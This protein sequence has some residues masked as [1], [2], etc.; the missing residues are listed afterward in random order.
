[1]QCMYNT[2]SKLS[3]HSLHGPF[4][5]W[6][7]LW[8]DEFFVIYRLPDRR[9]TGMQ[10]TVRRPSGVSCPWPSLPRRITVVCGSCRLPPCTQVSSGCHFECNSVGY[11]ECRIEDSCLMLWFLMWFLMWFFDV[12]F[13]CSFSMF[14][15]ATSLTNCVLC[16]ILCWFLIDV[17]MWYFTLWMY[18]IWCRQQQCRCLIF[19]LESTE[20]QQQSTAVH[21][22]SNDV[23]AA[24]VLK[25]TG[26][27]TGVQ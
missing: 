25:K 23:G 26:R 14:F 12:L 5:C 20:Q 11:C 10:R 9:P 3:F 18:W 27:T 15:D 13:R 21:S 19:F 16:G 1:M 6:H 24:V 8:F 4:K 7:F 17:P 22:A 2:F